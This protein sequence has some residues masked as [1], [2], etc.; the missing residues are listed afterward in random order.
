MARH[1]AFL[2]P[3][4]LALTGNGYAAPV[5]GQTRASPALQKDVL[6]SLLLRDR[7][8]APNC[9]HRRVVNTKVLET[10]DSNRGVERWTLKRCG[11]RVFYRVEYQSSPGGG[12]DYTVTLET[13]AVS[14]PPVGP[15]IEQPVLP[16]VGAEWGMRVK[17]TGSFGRGTSEM[18]VRMLG[19]QVWRGKRLIAVRFEDKDM[20]ETEYWTSEGDLVA[21]R[22]AFG[23]MIYDPPLVR[24]HW[25][26]RVGIMWRNRWRI[27]S[28]QG[29][30]IADQIVV[31]GAYKEITVPAGTFPCF[32]IGR[33]SSGS[34]VTQWWSPKLGIVIKS[35]EKT[36]RGSF[37][38]ELVWYRG[39]GHSA[40]TISVK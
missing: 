22:F 29:T 16:P 6:I 33:F 35:I 17:K 34:E 24:L 31:V 1:R 28:K 21:R 4:L 11:K 5:P 9:R 10:R 39:G 26:L 3:M 14:K 13:N 20:P 15:V 18:H 19:P 36:A 38:Q 40:G 2:L 8:I 25:P 37:A 32:E 27:R 12:T 23:E 7:L 30:A